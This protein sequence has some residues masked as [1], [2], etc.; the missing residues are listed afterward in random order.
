MESIIATQSETKTETETNTRDTRSGSA[1]SDLQPEGAEHRGSGGRKW[2]FGA[3]TLLLVWGVAY[4]VL[5]FTDR[6]PG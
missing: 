5:F 1:S 3:Y 4:L 6:L 2:V